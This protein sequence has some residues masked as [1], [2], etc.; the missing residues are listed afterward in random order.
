MNF[1]VIRNPRLTSV[2]SLNVLFGRNHGSKCSRNI[3]PEKEIALW[4]TGQIH[5]ANIPDTTRACWWLRLAGLPTQR[6]PRP[7]RTLRRAGLGN[8]CATGF[9]D[10]A[11]GLETESHSFFAK[12]WEH[13]G[14]HAVSTQTTTYAFHPWKQLLPSY[15][16]A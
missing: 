4:M 7:S 15:F 10:Q 11:Q 13:P 8:A 1:L 14:P 12:G 2:A 5:A 16:P 9:G 3:A 6:V